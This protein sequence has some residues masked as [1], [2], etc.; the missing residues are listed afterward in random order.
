M[1]ELCLHRGRL[2]GQTKASAPSDLEDQAGV[3]EAEVAGD[4]GSMGTSSAGDLCPHQIRQQLQYIQRRLHTGAAHT[5]EEL[6]IFRPA[7]CLSCAQPLRRA[8]HQNPMLLQLLV[9]GPLQRDLPRRLA[10]ANLSLMKDVAGVL[11]YLIQAQP[12]VKPQILPPHPSIGEVLER[13]AVPYLDLVWALRGSGIGRRLQESI[14]VGTRRQSLESPALQGIAGEMHRTRAHL[15]RVLDVIEGRDLWLKQLWAFAAAACCPN[16]PASAEEGGSD[17]S[18]A[19]RWMRDPMWD[20]QLLRHVFH[21]VW[22]A[23]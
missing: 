7:P 23:T 16:A 12:R 17:L 6:L 21:F 5:E 4:M 13:P 9:I 11:E 10:W 15:W 18:A 20:P 2:L 3:I 19:G 8:I 1:S 14:G 22:Q